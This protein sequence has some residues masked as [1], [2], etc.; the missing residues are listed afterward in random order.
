MLSGFPCLRCVRRPEISTNSVAETAA[1]SALVRASDASLPPQMNCTG[2]RIPARPGRRSK[3][4]SAWAQ[5]IN[6]FKRCRPDHVTH[7]FDRI[8]I[9]G[10]EFGRKPAL[11]RRLHQRLHAVIARQRDALFPL[12]RRIAASMPDRSRTPPRGRSGRD[13]APP[14]RRPSCRPS[15]IR[16]NACGRFRA[17]QS[18]R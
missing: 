10:D 14:A 5:P 11:D 13:A 4:D 16:R 1:C 18:I 12:L 2:F 7:F 15:T 8:R 6:P 3:F 17:H 9:A